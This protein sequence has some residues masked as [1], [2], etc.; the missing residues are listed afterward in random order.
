MPKIKTKQTVA[1]RFHVTSTGKV[2]RRHA[3]HDHFNA[4]DIGKVTRNKR[5]DDIMSPAFTKTIKTLTNQL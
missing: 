2:M 4:R 3:G 1:K 5:S